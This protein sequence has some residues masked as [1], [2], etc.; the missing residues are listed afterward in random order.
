MSKK[1]FG[2]TD[3]GKTV[4]IFTLSNERITLSVIELGAAIQS[5]VFDGKEMVLGYD[6]LGDYFKYNDCFGAVVGRYANR[7]ANGIFYLN[8]KKYELY[9]ND[10]N[11]TL[12]GG[13][14]GYDKVVWKGNEDGDSVSFEY[15][16]K[17]MEEGFPGNLKVRVEYKLLQDGI[18][19]SYAA[20]SD[21]D[22][23]INLSNH[24]YFNLSGGEDSVE[25]HSL[26]LDA[27]Y[28][29]PINGE[30]LPTGEFC[31]V[32]GTP[33]DF[34]T[35]KP[36]GKDINDDDKQLQLA[37][38]YDHNFVINGKGFRHF[39]KVYD[40]LKSIAMDGYTDMAG[41][42]F[43]SGNFLNERRIKNGKIIMKRYGLCLETQ[44]FPNSVN[45]STFPSSVLKA[46][47]KF[48]SRTSFRF[49]K[50]KTD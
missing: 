19:I 44:F 49:S 28:F 30:I 9:R 38:G 14:I 32:D 2:T 45:I 10:G 47:E 17:D 22:T 50:V 37:G 41:V 25:K 42:Q 16:S 4:N 31:S 26:S 21:K 13:K 36:I 7:I 24:T 34:R 33:F 35:V 48:T 12:H 40:P 39:A 23:V 8:G 11:N 5:L 43:Y 1:V 46:G 29:T 6:C 20:I 27:D 18:E 3:S 15:L